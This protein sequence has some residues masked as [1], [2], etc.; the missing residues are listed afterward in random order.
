MSYGTLQGVEK[1]LIYLLSDFPEKVKLAGETYAP[2]VIAQYVYDLAKEYNRFYAEL[3]IFNEQDEQARA[4][5]V[6]LSYMVAKVI[7]RG[8][9]LLGIDV[10]DRM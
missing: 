4:F 2:S 3:S 5:R 1:D 7:K 10:P 9:G 6:V 8:M